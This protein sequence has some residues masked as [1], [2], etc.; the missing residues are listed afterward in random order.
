MRIQLHLFL[1]TDTLLQ[2]FV[3]TVGIALLFIIASAVF[4]SD[5]GGSEL[6]KAAGVRVF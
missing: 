5:N 6:E 4:L 2:D 3:Y 1:N